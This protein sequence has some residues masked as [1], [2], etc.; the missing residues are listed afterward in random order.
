MTT[1]YSGYGYNACPDDVV[2]K[3]L[4]RAYSNNTKKMWQSKVGG[5]GGVLEGA[6]SSAVVSTADCSVAAADEAQSQSLAVTNVLNRP[7]DDS[8]PDRF[9]Y[10]TLPRA[11]PTGRTGTASREACR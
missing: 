3:Y 7:T 4:A 6:E 8:S 2:Y 10:R 11:S 1:G 5:W 9:H